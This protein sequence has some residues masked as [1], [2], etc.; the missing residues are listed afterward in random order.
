MSPQH[1]F[2][3][4]NGTGS[5]VRA[6]LNNLFKAILTNNSGTT[7]PSTVISSDAGSKAFSFWA[8][9]NSSPAVLKIRNA[10][11][12]GWI[13][14][15]QLDGTLT[16]EDGSA[17]APALANRGDLDTGVF[18]SAANTF[19]VATGGVERMELGATTIFNEDGADVDFRIE[20]DTDANNFYVDA[21]N[22][23]IGIGTSTPLTPDGSNADN[24]NNGKVFTIYGGSPAINLTHNTSGASAA[25][26]DY[27]AIN[28]GRTGST[29]NPYRATIGYKQSDDIL[30]INS[31]NIIAID[32]G[33]IGSDEKVRI[34]SSGRVMIG[35]TTEGNSDGDDLTVATTNNGGITI[36]TGTSSNGNLF[37]SDA[38]S[39]TAEYAGYIQYKH[40]SDRLDFGTATST[41]MTIDS[42]GN[43]GIGTSSPSKTLDIVGGEIRAHSNVSG[44]HINLRLKGQSTSTGGAIIA[45]NSAGNAGPLLFYVGGSTLA[46]NIN[47][48]GQVG[49]GLS[50]QNHLLHVQGASDITKFN[51]TST[52]DV[53]AIVMRHARGNLSGF[54]GKMISFTGNSDTEVG[55][56]RIGLNSTAYNTSSDYRLKENVTAIP[57]GITRLKTLKPYTFNWISDDTNTPVDGFFAHEVSSIVP[58]AITGTKD[59]VATEDSKQFK[60]GDPIYQSIDQSKLV[61]LLV[62]A[63]QELITKVETL[64]AT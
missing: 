63:V 24:P 26:S 57:D 33:T 44:S 46:M 19:N 39:G 10:A 51:C 27:A 8:D 14:L 32:M 18:F 45:E 64:E 5:A 36:R 9:T 1:D 2:V 49:I 56:I 31:N 3:I 43:V 60:K 48:S 13:E 38:T 58:E 53:T 37:F 17:S 54:S 35:T 4:D 47:T 6:D 25:S 52:G 34:D 50:D 12:D 30:R 28:F 61:P 16:L 23:A 21:A 55:S 22:N 62:A 20:G 59:A 15:F 11:D 42:S 29:T 7:D 40:S 41:R